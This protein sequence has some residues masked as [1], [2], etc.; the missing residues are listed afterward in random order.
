M[1][2]MVLTIPPECPICGAPGERADDGACQSCGSPGRTLSLAVLLNRVIE[3]M[4]AVPDLPLLG[5]A[6]TGAERKLLSRVFPSFTSASLYGSYGADHEEGVDARDLSHYA[7]G[8]KS[9]VFASLVLDYFEEHDQALEQAFRVTAEGGVFITHIA[10]YRLLGGAEPPRTT[11]LIEP[12]ADYF[13]YVPDGAEMP[14]IEV[15]ADWFFRALRRAGF[16]ATSVS[17]RDGSSPEL[18]WF[19]GVKPASRRSR[20]VAPS[21]G[22]RSTESFSRTC[23]IPVDPAHGFKR[24]T[25]ELTAPAVPTAGSPVNFAEHVLDPDRQ[26]TGTAIACTRG[27]VVVSE[28]LGESWEYI[29]IPE[30]SEIDL[31]NSF[32][33]RGGV[34]LLQGRSAA[35]LGVTRTDERL[36]GPVATL[37]HTWAFQHRTTPGVAMWHGSRSI[38]EADGAI[39]YAEYPDN[40]SAYAKD[41]DPDN[42]TPEQLE[43][44]HD[45]QLFRSVDGGRSWDS[46]LRVDWQTIRHFHTVAAD[47]WQAGRWWASSGDRPRE[48]R[49]WQSLD[50]G[51]NWAEIDCELPTEELSPFLANP[52]GVLRYTDLAIRED[53]LIWGADDWLGAASPR[54]AEAPMRR[55]GGSRIFRSRKP[56]PWQPESIGHV[57][58]PIRSLIDV[59][60]A[61]L[62]LTEAKGKLGR[63]Y[64]PQV[65]LLSKH[66]PFRLT[67]LLT[68]DNFGEPP[69][70]GFTLSR[71]S[72]AA[73]N[74]VFFTYRRSTDVFP[75]GANI[76]RWRVAFD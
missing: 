55:R 7:R 64:C 36:D 2:D 32:T 26:A 65:L 10:P 15:G 39:V 56:P 66:E 45:S 41:F 59:G 33:T 30:L 35:S 61:F 22:S 54:N 16:E 12:R 34:H 67:P 5:F 73:K 53:D 63:G 58:S 3:P 27:A 72:R 11:H 52:G 68:A 51:L 28:D 60:P 21:A 14:S 31:W 38:D 13:S 71:A 74:G 18:A 6:M 70:T 19:V 69:A 24:V 29:P 76:L 9:G 57:G 20:R 8:T 4:A 50:D 40:R 47:P 46:V 1:S 62:V 17:V 43:L 48:C 25:V 37:D 42:P 49:I 23:S 75:G 44:L